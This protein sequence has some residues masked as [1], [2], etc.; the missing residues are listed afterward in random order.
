[1]RH[2]ERTR[3]V[4]GGRERTGVEKEIES[5]KE[6]RESVE[7]MRKN[8]RRIESTDGCGTRPSQWRF[9]IERN[10]KRTTRR[11]VGEEIESK[12]A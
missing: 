6:K 10:R 7:G 1:M 12:P 2:N 9:Q 3:R 4:G 11:G 8:K 5:E